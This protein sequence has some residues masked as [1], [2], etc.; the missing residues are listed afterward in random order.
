VTNLFDK[1]I[2]EGFKPGDTI[3]TTGKY[4]VKHTNTEAEIMELPKGERFPFGLPGDFPSYTWV[5]AS[6]EDPKSNP[7]DSLEI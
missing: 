1:Y 6:N 2:K 3:P 4:E 5:S 7:L